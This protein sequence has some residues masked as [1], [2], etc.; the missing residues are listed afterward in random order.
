[1]PLSVHTKTP[2]KERS[3]HYSFANRTFHVHRDLSFLSLRRPYFNVSSIY[4]LSEPCDRK[5]LF[6]RFGKSLCLIFLTQ[7][8]NNFAAG[9]HEISCRLLHLLPQARQSVAAG[10]ENTYI[11]VFRNQLSGCPCMVYIAAYH[12]FSKDNPCWQG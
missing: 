2:T 3:G 5:N 4:I 6:V 9:L 10:A 11:R 8:C 1:M 12:S 7:A